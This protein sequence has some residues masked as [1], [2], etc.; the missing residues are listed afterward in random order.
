MHYMAT[1]RVGQQYT[2]AITMGIGLVNLVM[3]G[4]SR[5]P[6][7][8]TTAGDS[9]YNLKELDVRHIQDNLMAEQCFGHRSENSW[10]R[11]PC[12]TLECQPHA[13]YHLSCTDRISVA[14]GM[15]TLQVLRK[16][17]TQSRTPDG[18]V[19]SPTRLTRSRWSRAQCSVGLRRA[20]CASHTSNYSGAEAR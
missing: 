4:P 6:K 16:L 12:I 14:L 5:S 8:Y 13:H 20:F 17:E 3:G 18:K 1:C 11:K 9:S 19:V 10:P 7:Q 15:Q 2:V